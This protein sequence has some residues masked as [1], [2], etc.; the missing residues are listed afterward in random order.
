[1]VASNCRRAYRQ[2]PLGLEQQ[3]DGHGAD[4]KRLLHRFDATLR[5]GSAI[6][7]RLAQHVVAIDVARR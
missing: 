3:V 2:Q 7:P 6:E 4:D 1:L 5:G